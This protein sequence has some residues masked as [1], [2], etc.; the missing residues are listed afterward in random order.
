MRP[1]GAPEPAIGPADLGNSSD[2]TSGRDTARSGSTGQK[3]STATSPSQA[4][5][6]IDGAQVAATQQHHGRAFPVNLVIDPAQ[7]LS[8]TG[9]ICAKGPGV[10]PE[11][12][13][14]GQSPVAERLVALPHRSRYLEEDPDFI[15]N[16]DVIPEDEIP[17]HIDFVNDPRHEF[18]K[19]DTGRQNWYHHDKAT[20]RRLWAPIRFD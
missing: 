17:S 5:S 1:T 16:A 18:W 3:A 12:A 10:I 15:L 6:S 7:I 2:S 8:D 11:P 4:P 14:A 19:W 9:R 13:H 20:N